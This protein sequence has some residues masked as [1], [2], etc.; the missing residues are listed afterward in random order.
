VFVLKRLFFALWPSAEVRQKIAKLNQQVSLDGVRKLKPN[1]LHMTLLYLGNIDAVMQNEIVLKVAGL[2][3]APF[4]F[5]LD[6][7]QYWRT[8]K[9]ICLTVSQ[10]PKPLLDLANQLLE[11]CKQYP[12][13]LHDRPYQGHVTLMR[14]AKQAYSLNY[15]PIQWQANEFV[16]VESISTTD[17]IR[18]DILMRWPL[19]SES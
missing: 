8:P 16:L 15:A 17:G 2:K 9:V 12:I 14:K 6:A 3:C 19:R 11:I 13:H 5:Q 7:M 18:Y 4:S 1:N 10:Q